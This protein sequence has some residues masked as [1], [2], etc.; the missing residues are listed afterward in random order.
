M[1][2]KVERKLKFKN[3]ALRL[4]GDYQE[5]DKILSNFN[6]IIRKLKDNNLQEYLNILKNDKFNISTAPTPIIED[7]D[8]VLPI[9]LY[10][11]LSLKENIL[12]VLHGSKKVEGLSNSEISSSLNL[13]GVSCKPG[14]VRGTISHLRKRKLVLIFSKQKPYRYKLTLNGIQQVQKLLNELEKR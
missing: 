12:L 9:I 6:Q 3:I 10:P 1:K 14:G 8:T 4:S 11:D 5:L 13:S 2:L 7:S